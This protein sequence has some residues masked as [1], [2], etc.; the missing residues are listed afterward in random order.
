MVLEKWGTTT[1][2]SLVQYSRGE[3][4]RCDCEYVQQKSYQV[5]SGDLV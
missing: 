5:A 2:D 1:T 4:R 3:A